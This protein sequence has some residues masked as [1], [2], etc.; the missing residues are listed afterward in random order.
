MDSVVLGTSF[1]S[2]SFGSLTYKTNFIIQQ[3]A[4]VVVTSAKCLT[5]GLEHSSSHPAHATCTQGAACTQAV[6]TRVQKDHIPQ[7]RMIHAL[8]TAAPDSRGANRQIVIVIT[9]PYCWKTLPHCLKPLPQNFK[10]QCSF[11]FLIF[12]F[13]FWGARHRLGHSKAIAYMGEIRK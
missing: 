4:H 3:F 12:L 7:V 8:K 1:T 5:Q 6:R 11:P 10:G 9:Y 13:P 2:W